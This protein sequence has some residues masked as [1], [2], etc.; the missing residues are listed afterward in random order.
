MATANHTTGLVLTLVAI[1]CVIDPVAK[2]DDR[3]YSKPAPLPP[4]DFAAQ[5]A[6]LLTARC[7]SCHNAKRSRSGLDLSTVKATHTGGKSGP[8]VVPFQPDES[9]LLDQITPPDD[10]GRPEMPKTGDPFTL[11]QVALI[12]RW[13]AEGARWPDGLVLEAQTDSRSSWWSLQPLAKVGPPNPEGLP[14]NWS[15]NPIDRFVFARLRE[16]GLSPAA[17]ADRRTLIRRASFDLLGLPPAVTDVEAFVRDE[18]PAAFEELIDRYLNAPQYGEHWGRHW[19]DIVRFAESDGFVYDALREQAWPYRD[20]V[21]RSFNLDKPYARFIEEQ[22]AGD[23][24]EPPTSDGIVATGVLVAGPFDKMSEMSS[25]GTMRARTREEELEE[26]IATVSQTFLGLTVNCARCHDH[27]FDPIPQRDY[28]RLKAALEGVHRGKRAILTPAELKARDPR[29]LTQMTYTAK[30]SE[31]P[32]THVLAR[33]DVEQPGE[34]VAAGGLSALT[35][36]CDD[37]GLPPDAPE[38]ERRRKLAG[39]IAHPQNPLTARVLVN[40]VWQYHFGTG[41]VGTANDF[42]SNGELPSHP[43]LLDWLAA[44][45]L[46]QGGRLK[47]LHRLIMLSRTYQQASRFDAKAAAIDAED[48][49][50]WRF[51]P[52]RLEAEAVRDAMLFASGELNY[53]M[54]GPSFRPFK[55]AQESPFQLLDPDGPEF[56]RRTIYR[57]IVHSARSP[58]LDGLDCPEPSVRTPRRALTTTPSQALALMNDTTMIRQAQKLA[59]RAARDAREAVPAQVARAY[60]LALGR[61]PTPQESDRAVALARAHGLDTVCWALFNS[62]EFLYVK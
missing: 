1:V 10:G 61:A 21:I 33:G 34:Q 29:T 62:S 5:V 49:L 22:I 15:S 3:A 31:P 4:V 17:P 39:W 8:A 30:P 7:L 9:L 47:P 11:E 38:A 24:L 36:L 54:G 19:L 41:L 28:Y 43:E 32:P 18:R 12:R 60:H 44:E 56:N 2:A 37:F 20:Y 14:S 53:K 52:R 25:S 23:V 45:F 13:I 57:M 59:E 46:A 16:R 35:S 6:P 27:K 55:P 42:G 26:M 58:L 48:R 51:P 50:L 40:R